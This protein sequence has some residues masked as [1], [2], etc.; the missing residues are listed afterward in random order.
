MADCELFIH[1]EINKSVSFQADTILPTL[2][3]VIHSC[4]SVVT[5]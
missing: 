2:I 1:V 3:Q 4:F 5:L